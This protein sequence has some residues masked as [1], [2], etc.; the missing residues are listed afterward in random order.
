MSSQHYETGKS[1]L[2]LGWL[3]FLFKKNYPTLFEIGY[4]QLPDAP[5]RLPGGKGGGHSS[6]RLAALA[7]ERW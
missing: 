7:S 2:P 6:G 4:A 5:F 3:L 1:H